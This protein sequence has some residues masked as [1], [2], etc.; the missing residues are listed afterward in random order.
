MTGV[1]FL[2]V[3]R[4][5][6]RSKRLGC[7]DPGL[8]IATLARPRD[9]LRARLGAHGLDRTLAA[10][11]PPEATAALALRARRLI[12]MRYRRELAASYR[13][14]VRDAG[15]GT[16]SRAPVVPC[17][18]RVTA[19]AEALLQLADALVEPGPVSPQGVAEAVLLL[20]DGSG[21]LYNGGSD[22]DLSN[23]ASRAAADL[24]PLS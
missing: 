21:P 8:R 5:R 23:Q 11:A 20:V 1:G 17:R 7:G 15:E 24:E 9:R 10:G 12:A 6:D 14:I 22:S 3:M 13:R 16:P 4:A 19:A 18:P 2:P